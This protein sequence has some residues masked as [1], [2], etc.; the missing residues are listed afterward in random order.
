MDHDQHGAARSGNEPDPRPPALRTR[1][2]G[3]ARRESTGRS[4]LARGAAALALAV[5]AG[6]NGGCEM[7]RI[8]GIYRIDVQQGN[9]VDREMLNQL[10]IG[11]DTR[12]VRFIMGTPLLGDPFHRDRWDYVYSL[13]TGSGPVVAQRVTLY[14]VDDRLARIEDHLDPDAVPGMAS[15]RIPT[16]VTVPQRRTRKGFLDALVPDFLKRDGE[17]APAADSSAPPPEA[18]TE[19]DTDAAPS[20]T[21]ADTTSSE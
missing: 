8:P 21:E 14:F 9:A 11:M 13:R 16:L 4:R 2:P 17:R 5:A 20:G 1:A 18:D 19:E 3:I 15:E 12:K 10:E 7:P 6:V